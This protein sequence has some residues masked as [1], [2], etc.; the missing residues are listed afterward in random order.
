MKERSNVLRD[1]EVYELKEMM[2]LVAIRAWIQE[3][4]LGVGVL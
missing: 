1:N 3:L 4:C 2:V